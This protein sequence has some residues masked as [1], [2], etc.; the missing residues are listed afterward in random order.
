MSNKR[1]AAMIGGCLAIVIAVA[2][3]AAFPPAAGGS[4]ADGVFHI[5]IIPQTPELIDGEDIFKYSIAGQQFV[6][7]VTVTDEGQLSGLPVTISAKATGADVVIYQQNILP[8]QVAEVFVTPG[9]K[10]IGKTIK[11]TITGTQGKLRD[12]EVVKFIVA[13]G[14]DDRAEYAAELLDRFVS[15]FAAN[16]TE[17]GIT[18]ATAW[19]G[20]MVSPV[21][22]VVSHYLFFSTEWEVHIYWHIMVAPYDWARIDLRHRFDELAPSY[23]FEISSLTATDLPIPIEVPEAVWR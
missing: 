12:K 15:W 7:L 14:E 4:N 21:W 23:S 1:L 17:L 18:E 10:S 20:T 3:V 22:L 6:F 9:Q 11:V 13:E 8:G 16:Q 19:N 2:G 5:D